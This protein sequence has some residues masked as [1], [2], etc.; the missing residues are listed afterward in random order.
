M[1]AES[2]QSNFRRR[3]SVERTALGAI[4]RSIPSVVLGR[5]L[6]IFREAQDRGQDAVFLIPSRPM[7][8]RSARFSASIRP[9]P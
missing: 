3:A 4:W 8:R 5:P 2:A 7:R 6:E 9:M 1:T